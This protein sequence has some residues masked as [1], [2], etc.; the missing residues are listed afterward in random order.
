MLKLPID[1]LLPALLDTLAKHTKAVLTAPP[2][3]GK[4]TRIPLTLLNALDGRP[5]PIYGDGQQVRDWLHVDD[6][7][8]A[9]L[10]IL[11]HGRIGA[12]YNIGAGNERTNLEVVDAICAVLDRLR[13]P[14]MGLSSYAALK[15]FV[16]DRPGHDRRYAIDATRL[17]TELGWAPSYTFEA[18]LEHTVRWY[19]ENRRWCDEVQARGYQRER[20]GLASTMRSAAI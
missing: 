17:R 13:P 18:G 2:G 5:L 11:R 3:S 4:T 8:R 9:L 14:E 10:L 7:C 6:H 19:L 15:T 1:E 20:L 12:K 16:P